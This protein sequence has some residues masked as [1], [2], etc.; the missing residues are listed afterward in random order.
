MGNAAVQNSTDTSSFLGNHL[1]DTPIPDPS[2]F[3][4]TVLSPFYLHWFHL[5]VLICTNTSLDRGQN[6]CGPQEMRETTACPQ[7]KGSLSQLWEG[8]AESRAEVP[9][10]QQGKDRTVH[11]GTRPILH[12][13]IRVPKSSA[14]CL[15]T[16]ARLQLFKP[17][18]TVSAAGYHLPDT[19]CHIPSLPSTD[20][21]LKPCLACLLSSLPELPVT[22]EL[23]LCPLCHP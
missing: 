11:K 9:A 3:V 17:E 22:S 20:Q 16:C 18:H 4:T 12:A 5:H 8:E 15:H 10:Q 19:C 2:L 1:P 14:D 23:C 7:L 21:F 6:H 13:R